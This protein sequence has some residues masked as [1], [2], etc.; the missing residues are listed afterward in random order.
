MDYIGCIGIIQGL[1]GNFQAYVGFGATT[2]GEPNGKDMENDME[3][4]IVGILLGC[5]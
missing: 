4:V 3:T 5:C 1:Q 2:N